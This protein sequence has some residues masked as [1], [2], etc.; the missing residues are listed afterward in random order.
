MKIPIESM[1]DR[2]HAA[3]VGRASLHTA[4]SRAS[5]S[6]FQY[7]Y[8]TLSTLAAAIRRL[9]QA[10]PLGGGEAL[11][12]DLGSHR[13]PY[14]EL[15]ERRGYS[16]RTLDLT[17]GSGADYVGTVEDT[18]LG[19]AT[20]DLVLCTQVIEHCDDPKQAMAEIR[21]I[22]KPSGYLI[23][24]AP[25]VWFYHPHPHDHWRFTQEGL[26]RLCRDAGLEPVELLGQGG[27][28]LT[29]AQV[30]SFLAYGVLGRIGAPIY[31]ML[32]VAGLLGDRM[33][34]N[35]LF[36]HNFACLA[37]PMQPHQPVGA[38]LHDAGISQ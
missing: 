5:P 31:W 36:C 29:V 21:R 3:Q 12:L 10:I 23:V 34:P 33:L 6:L 35:E 19:E 27:T 16:M 26:V 13:S 4:A 28:V 11:A 38:L 7:D 24:S 20:F 37:V 32:N 18:K 1:Q 8:L 2:F 25:H 14:R 9:V 17:A 22:L 15:V 30:M